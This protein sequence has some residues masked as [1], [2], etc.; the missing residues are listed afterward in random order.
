MTEEAY[1]LATKLEPLSRII[2]TSAAELFFATGQY[3]IAL[4]RVDKTLAFAP[5]FAFA[6]QTKAT[7]HIARNEF[8]EA[9]VAFQKQSELGYPIISEQKTVNFIEESIRT[10]KSVK[11]P[12]WLNDPS[13]SDP[14][15][16]SIVLVSAGQYEQTLDLIERHATSNIPHTAAYNL[17]TA[18]FREKMGHLPRYQEL[19]T[20][21]ATFEFD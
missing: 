13:L 20:R 6:W 7:F 18:L 12:D 2:N 9:R 19:V 17:H 8:A 3:D 1:Q 11:Q 14:Y 4:D 5:D 10:G 21:L 15:L 16:A